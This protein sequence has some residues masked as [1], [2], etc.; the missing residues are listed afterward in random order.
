MN[1][2]VHP[3]NIVCASMTTTPSPMQ[4]KRL[5]DRFL[6]APTTENTLKKKTK[7]RESQQKSKLNEGAKRK[8]DKSKK[9]Q[10][11]KKSDNRENNWPLKRI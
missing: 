2:N 1:H 7:E 6:T 3:N 11:K 4:N 9:K 10:E 5:Y 8:H